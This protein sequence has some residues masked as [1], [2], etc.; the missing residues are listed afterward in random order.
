MITG[1]QA[2]LANA[3]RS[4]YVNKLQAEATAS[5]PRVAKP[6]EIPSEL[7]QKS[8]PQISAKT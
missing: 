2:K 6:A 1:G 4:F 3:F 7:N 8:R 5:Y